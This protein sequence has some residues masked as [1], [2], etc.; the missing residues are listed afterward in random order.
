MKPDKI[1]VRMIDG[2]E[3]F[4][5]PIHFFLGQ[6]A[7]L[8][9]APQQ[10]LKARTFSSIEAGLVLSEP[11]RPKLILVIGL[12]KFCL[13]PSSDFRLARVVKCVSL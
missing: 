8:V 3:R 11:A 10:Q 9:V 6:L 4:S 5:E 13:F 12:V 1:T 2:S 7:S